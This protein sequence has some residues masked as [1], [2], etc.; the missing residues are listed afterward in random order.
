MLSTRVLR[1]SMRLPWATH[2]LM[3]INSSTKA[4]TKCQLG[5]H[6]VT[7]AERGANAIRKVDFSKTTKSC[8]LHRISSGVES[9]CHQAIA[10]R[11]NQLGK[12]SRVG[13]RCRRRRATK[14]HRK[15]THHTNLPSQAR[16][17]STRTWQIL[18]GRKKQLSRIRHQRV[19]RCGAWAVVVR[20][21][22]EQ[23]STT[24]SQASL[25][26]KLNSRRQVHS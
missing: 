7:I 21:S 22:R 26:H 11:R 25:K 23:T 16:T 3:P 4:L 18:S 9:D 2:Q 13:R 19:T 5:H 20:L 1:M 15:N 8:N 24:S 12:G 10:L 6:Q 14:N 17:T